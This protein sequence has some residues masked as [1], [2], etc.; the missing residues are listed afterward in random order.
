MNEK[1][2]GI[3]TV[4]GSESHTTFGAKGQVFV[5]ENGT[6]TPIYQSRIARLISTEWE[7]VGRKGT[8]G[9]WATS[10]YLVPDGMILK[11]FAVHTAG[12][13][14]DE[15]GS[16]FFR[17][18]VS[19]ESRK[20]TGGMYAQERGGSIYGPMVRLSLEEVEAMGIKIDPKYRRYYKEDCIHF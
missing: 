13:H 20:A 19:Q 4:T 17:V 1:M 18:D 14:I 15:G 2:I 7:E 8:H 11:L 9:K 6:E 5:V 10:E 3:T 12:A 16:A